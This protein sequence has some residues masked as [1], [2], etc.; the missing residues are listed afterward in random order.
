MQNILLTYPP[1]EDR[2][3]PLWNLNENRIFIVKSMYKNLASHWH[4]RSFKHLW[5]TKILPKI[6]ICL[7]MIWHNAITTKNNMTKRDWI[8]DTKCRLCDEEEDIH[9]L[10]FLCPAAKYMWSVVSITLG[11]K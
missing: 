8:G 10:F 3:K 6:K 4:N 1:G 11:G 9:H 2:D 5:K 7:W